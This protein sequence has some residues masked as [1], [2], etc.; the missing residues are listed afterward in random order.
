MRTG[1]LSAPTAA[2]LRANPGLMKQVFAALCRAL[3]HIAGLGITIKTKKTKYRPGTAT[4]NVQLFVCRDKVVSEQLRRHMGV[5]EQAI[6]MET[7]GHHGQGIDDRAQPGGA[8]DAQGSG[9]P[10]CV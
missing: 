9:H 10:C 3:E 8:A 2:A 1:T 4:H 5:R 7:L 6:V